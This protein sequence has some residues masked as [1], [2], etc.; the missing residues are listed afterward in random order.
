MTDS[1]RSTPATPA[2]KPLDPAERRVLGVLIEK[3]KTTPAGYPMTVNAIVTGCNQKNNRE[4][5]T[6]TV[7]TRFFR[8]TVPGSPVQVHTTDE[9]SAG[10]RSVP[11]IAQIAS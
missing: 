11:V 6:A 7:A 4:P 3:A 8:S 1:S 5:V 10:A 2:W 9:L